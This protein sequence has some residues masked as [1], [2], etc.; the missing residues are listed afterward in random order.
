M[1]MEYAEQGDLLKHINSKM[2]ETEKQIQH[3]FKQLLSAVSACHRQFIT[4]R[5]LKCDNILLTANGDVKITG[6]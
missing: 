3:H 5:D 2:Y 1:V 4:H 6:K